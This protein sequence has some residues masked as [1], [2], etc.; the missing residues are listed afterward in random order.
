MSDWTRDEIEITTEF[1]N[2]FNVMNGIVEDAN[3]GDPGIKTIDWDYWAGLQNITPHQCAKLVELI[4]PILWPGNT[5]A[6]GLLPDDMEERITRLT[7][8]M[9][10]QSQLWSLSSLV[11]TLGNE[12]VPLRMTHTLK[13]ARAT[14]QPETATGSADRGRAI[15]NVVSNSGLLK[16]PSRKDDWFQAIDDMTLAFH[17]EFGSIPNE[18]QAWGRLWKKPPAG[19][20][21]TTGTDKG[22]EDCLKMP[23]VSALSRTAFAKRWA[24]YSRQ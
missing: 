14:K 19:Y 6:P 10:S 24:S 4:D 1:I 18:V 8:Q 22:A 16:E 17:K 13:G 21:I 2:N 9:A 3:T 7:Q 5:Y 11:E 20:E 12:N 23:G 15:N